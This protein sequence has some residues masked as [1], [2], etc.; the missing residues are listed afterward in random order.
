M[1]QGGTIVAVE[2][3]EETI[4]RQ[5]LRNP[6]NGIRSKTVIKVYVGGKRSVH[7]YLL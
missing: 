5:V 2:L 1:L 7:E 4:R 6:S 3:S